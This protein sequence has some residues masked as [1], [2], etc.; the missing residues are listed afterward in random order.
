MSIEEKVIE[1]FKE[2]HLDEYDYSLMIYINNKIKVKIICKKHGIFEQTPH[3]HKRGGG[4]QKCANVGARRLTNEEFI[5]KA[6]IKHNNKYEYSISNY[7]TNRCKVKVM[8]N[9]H[10]IFEPNAGQH[11]NGQGCPKCILK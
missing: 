2:K 3:H 11:L 4:C 9:E 6:N 5:N 8:C 1:K 10:G 7:T